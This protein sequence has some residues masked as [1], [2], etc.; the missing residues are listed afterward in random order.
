MICLSSKSSAKVIAMSKINLHKKLSKGDR[1]AFN[2]KYSFINNRCAGEVGPCHGRKRVPGSQ[3]AKA[4]QGGKYPGFTGDFNGAIP[5]WLGSNRP[6]SD[7]PFTA[8]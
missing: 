7:D 3:S 2:R 1:D 6:G 8:D 5:S 4:D